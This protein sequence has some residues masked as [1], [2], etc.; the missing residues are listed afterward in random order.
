MI[1]VFYG[2]PG[3]GKSYD[4]LRDLQD[5][6][7][8]GT[9][10]I[11]TNLSIDLGKF[12]AYLA[13]EFPD[14][15]YGDIN[16]RIRIITEEE[17]KLFYAFRHVA[18]VALVVPERHESLAGKHV[19]YSDAPAVA[20]YIDEAHI[21]F[22][23]REW[24]NTG[25]ELTYY[26]SQHRKL[27]DE[28]IFITQHPD[29]LESRLRK[30]AQEFWSHNNNAIERFW[31][32]FSK[33][34]YFSVEV[35]RK[36]P[37]GPNAPSPMATYRFRLNKKLADCYDTSAGIGIKGRKKP[38]KQRKKGLSL[39][40]LGVP[41]TLIAVFLIKAPDVATAGFKQ[42]LEPATKDIAMTNP[43]L[44]APSPSGRPSGEVGT[45][46]SVVSKPVLVRSYA[47]KGKNI[48]VTLTDGQT[49]TA[50]SGIVRMTQD[51]VEMR[52]GTKYWV[53]RGKLSPPAPGPQS[54]Q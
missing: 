42:V 33:P 28:C 54:S 35:H 16:Q 50:A 39:L 1:R 10:L 49:L 48:L 6:I 14:V 13:A 27:N 12:N 53:Q 45:I 26:A 19:D 15:D 24:A 9:R 38:E 5:E 37:T 32:F 46:P 11:V 41:I 20:Y 29:M 2:T 36:P 43:A 25:P 8:W 31:T 51:Y 18:Q 21:A 52:D 34:S 30:L 17:T 22:D 3:A 47:V 4:S 40:W 7:L 44:M 23:A